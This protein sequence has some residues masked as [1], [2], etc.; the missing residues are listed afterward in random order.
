M[1]ALQLPRLPGA[2]ASQ[3][4]L[5]PQ[6]AGAALALASSVRPGESVLA[7]TPAAGGVT[8]LIEE[9]RYFAPEL[10]VRALPDWELLPYDSFSPHPDIVASRVRT[11][12]DLARG[13]TH[14]VLVAPVG[15]LMQRLPPP[16]ALAWIGRWKPGDLLRRS[17]FIEQLASTGYVR[18]ESVA[19]VG[20]YA[21]RGSVLDV[22]IGGAGAPVRIELDGDEVVSLRRFDPESQRSGAP[23][24]AIRLL[25]GR[26]YPF[27]ESARAAFL[28]QWRCTFEGESERAPI[29]RQVEAGI[30]PA[31]IEF[32]L[33]LFYPEMATLPDYLIETARIVTLGDWRGAAQAHWEHIEQRHRDCLDDA[34][35][36]PL[37][38]ERLFLRP[39]ELK[40]AMQPF[41]TL[42]IKET[43]KNKSIK[44]IGLN[45]IPVIQS[46]S[47]AA[48]RKH[49]QTHAGKAVLLSASSPGRR[50]LLRELTLSAGLNPERV[51]SWDEFVRTA[52][53]LGIAGTPMRRGFCSGA[54]AVIT[55]AELLDAPGPARPNAGARTHQNTD[56]LR[57][58]IAHLGELRDGALVVH[59]RFGIGRYR[60]LE[61]LGEN[62]ERAEFATLEY[63]GGA[64]VHV[65]LDQLGALSRFSGPAS[66]PLDTLGGKRWQ[67]ARKRA[68]ERADDIAAELL[69]LYARRL[70]QKAP[71]IRLPDGWDSFGAA[72]PYSTT[73]DQH[74][75]IE[76][77]IGDLTSG[78]PMDRLV[79]GDV[80]FGKTEVAMRAAY[81]VVASGFQ[82]AVLSPTTLLARQHALTWTDRFADWPVKIAEFSALRGRPAGA[83]GGRLIDASVN[84]AIG[85]HAL[86]NRDFSR[87]GLLIVDEEHRF[88]V[89]H[90]EQLRRQFA[91]THLLSLTATPIPR[92]LNMALS[93]LRDISI[94]A[95]SPEHRL[96]IRTRVLRDEG[97]AV[98][99]AIQRELLRGGQIYYVHNR[100]QS[101]D[102]VREHVE[103][104]VPQARIGTAHGQMPRSR[105][106]QVM[107]GFYRG[108]IDLLICSSIIESGLDVPRANT[109]IIERAERFGMAQLHQIRGRVGRSHQQAYAY[110]LIGTE[111]EL[112]G[113]AM[114]RLRA[115]E[116][117]SEPGAGFLLASE[118]LDIRGAGELLGR[119]QSGSMADVGVTLFSSMIDESV[120]RARGDA[121]AHSAETLIEVALQ[122]PAYIP[123]KYIG[124][125][126]LRL[127][128]YRRAAGATSPQSLD[129]LRAELADRFGELPDAVRGWLACARLRL[130]AAPLGI[131]KLSVSGQGGYAELQSD[132]PV[133]VEKLVAMIAAEPERYRIQGSRVHCR[134]A[135]GD[136]DAREGLADALL[137]ALEGCRG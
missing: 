10:P 96:P 67:R 127:Q 61:V 32:Y 137:G 100:V 9:I 114:R 108:E 35:H 78:A 106:E 49:L 8:D 95:T 81:A 87:L 94:I 36:P 80:G 113:D 65:G 30:P 107:R 70:E 33:P 85:T 63:S 45:D 62:E 86:L 71:N 105:L 103:R 125:A 40:R 21:I 116:R 73:P 123:E 41:S 3:D 16:G 60:G 13:Q 97:S 98:R 6:L 101:L 77:V 68:E 56:R 74:S 46:D 84:I 34:V 37:P 57:D 58:A 118:D 59:R 110:F 99:E 2:P 28:H 124:D 93:G 31:G 17:A 15:A 47:D 1:S 19:A 20:E 18:V 53:D 29:C 90:K 109:V 122:R 50:E 136:A 14:G 111:A 104:L 83:A 11:L 130:R 22:F 129:A 76:A 24:E 121:T 75:A 128:L 72:F 43:Q 26:E 66:T 42:E 23:E 88:G 112:K 52:P 51:E 79:C 126:P 5:I 82:V 102:E 64:L 117:A 55:D 89:S 54:F 119:R 12:A 4:I 44:N 92:T 131:R 133:S 39:A 7:V 135:A 27:T 48:L 132:T 25:P 38:P 115:V 120:R 134:G 91:S 69:D